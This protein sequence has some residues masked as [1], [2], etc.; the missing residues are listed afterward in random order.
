MFLRLQQFSKQLPSIFFSRHWRS[1]LSLQRAQRFQQFTV[2]FS[3]LCSLRDVHRCENTVVQVQRGGQPFWM[4]LSSRKLP[5]T[6]GL[7]PQKTP[8]E[9]P[10]W[11]LDW[12]NCIGFCASCCCVRWVSVTSPEFSTFLGWGYLWEQEMTWLSLLLLG[13]FCL[14]ASW[15]WGNGILKVVLAGLFSSVTWTH[16]WDYFIC[17]FLKKLFDPDEDGQGEPLLGLLMSAYCEYIIPG[18]WVL[19]MGCVG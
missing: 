16:T 3:N 1:W 2:F 6:H 11:L 13:Q 14:R 12:S 15:N 9:Q 17:C 7:V 4:V 19:A 8:G 5:Y 10:G 18:D